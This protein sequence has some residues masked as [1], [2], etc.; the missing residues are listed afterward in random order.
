MDFETKRQHALLTRLLVPSLG[1]KAATSLVDILLDR[2][3]SIPGVLGASDE[4]L[5][6][7]LAARPDAVEV[8]IAARELAAN[9]ATMPS[10][11]APVDI[12]DRR[13][14]HYLINRIG[15]RRVETMLAVFLDSAGRFIRD[16]IIAEGATRTM[17]ASPRQ[18][19]QR[20]LDLSASGLVLAH[21]HPS[22][23]VEPSS[24]DVR[25]T[26]Q[27][28]NV[29]SVLEI[30]LLEHVVVTSKTTFCMRKAELL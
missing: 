12:A 10:G 15:W 18:I 30:S 5:R 26:L 16:E 14:H 9:S 1:G 4:A 27:L 8:I 22:G 24:A 29:A 25:W 20:A 19:V 23:S 7:S 3:G 17:F 28:S 2:F 11:Q 13:F 6:S 21:N